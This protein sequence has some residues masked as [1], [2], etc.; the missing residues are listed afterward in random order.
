MDTIFLIKYKNMLFSQPTKNKDGTHRTCVVAT[1]TKL[2]AQTIVSSIYHT[3][4]SNELSIFKNDEINEITM[5]AINI[6]DEEFYKMLHLNNFALMLVD[7]VHKKEDF[8]EVGGDI[9]EY[10]HAIGDEHAEY[11][12]NIYKNLS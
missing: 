7:T 4:K 6:K 11:I 2:A 12:D 8:F 5:S 9:I 1:K 10:E 3:K